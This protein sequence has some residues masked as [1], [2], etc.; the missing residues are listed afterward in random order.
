MDETNEKE[1]STLDIADKPILREANKEDVQANEE[2][3]QVGIDLDLLPTDIKVTEHYS[4]FTWL[5]AL[6]NIL[7]SEI[8]NIYI[9]VKLMLTSSPSI[10]LHFKTRGRVFRNRGRMIQDKSKES[11]SKYFT[12]GNILNK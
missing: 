11:K 1:S 10:L 5:L 4:R 6:E 7:R 8:Q 3:A 9:E 2:H 12:L